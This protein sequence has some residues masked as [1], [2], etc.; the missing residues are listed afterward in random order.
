[1]KKV[2]T[3]LVLL[4]AI[5]TSVLAQKNA[6]PV[7]STEVYD[8]GDVDEGPLYTA[9]FIVTN[10]GTEDLLFINSSTSCGCTVAKLPKQKIAPGASDTI[11]VSFNSNRRF[12][13]F[14]KDVRLWDNEGTKYQLR[15]RGYVKPERPLMELEQKTIDLGEISNTEDKE[16][17]I[18]F[19]NRGS[20]DLVIASVKPSCGYMFAKF[21]AKPTEFNGTDEIVVKITTRGRS[22]EFTCQI[23][24]QSNSYVYQPVTI[25]GKIVVGK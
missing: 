24:I 1:M 12:G 16:V 19:K 21:N 10:E 7:F 14:T 4:L 11:L 23:N 17:I 5:S 2:T 13:T 3:V 9:K 22:G 25:K 18:K 20:Q 15:I 8:F 6:K